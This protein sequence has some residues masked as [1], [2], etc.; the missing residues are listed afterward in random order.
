MIIEVK[1]NDKWERFTTCH[2]EFVKMYREEAKEFYEKH[3]GIKDIE[4]RAR[5]SHKF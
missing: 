5:E 4:V 1:R 2:K 3:Y